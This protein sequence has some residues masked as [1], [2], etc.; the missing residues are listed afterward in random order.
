M[1]VKEL[2]PADAVFAGLRCV[3]TVEI[4]TDSVIFVVPQ[5]DLHGQLDY[6]ATVNSSVLIE[7][8][9]QA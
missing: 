1:D 5:Y 6:A 4:P 3:A 8:V 2:V 7:N 9:R